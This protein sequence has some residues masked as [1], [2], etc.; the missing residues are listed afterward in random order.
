MEI[1]NTAWLILIF[2][3]IVY[4]NLGLIFYNHSGTNLSLLYFDGITTAVGIHCQ[5]L[6]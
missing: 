4:W 1:R 2:E 5:N 3:Y 6:F